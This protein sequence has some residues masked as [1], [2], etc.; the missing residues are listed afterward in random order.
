MFCIG[1][2]LVIYDYVKDKHGSRKFWVRADVMAGLGY[3]WKFKFEDEKSRKLNNLKV[4]CIG[5][6]SDNRKLVK[7][8]FDLYIWRFEESRK[9]GIIVLD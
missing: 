7:E 4:S 3:G 5:D 1:N 8:M 6:Y 2:G 9:T